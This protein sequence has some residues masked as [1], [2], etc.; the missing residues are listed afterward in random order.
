MQIPAIY[1]L[2][3][4]IVLLPCNN[5]QNINV[6]LYKSKILRKGNEKD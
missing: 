3:L 2:S 5:I 4:N 6:F 1:L